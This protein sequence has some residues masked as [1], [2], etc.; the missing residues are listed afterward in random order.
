ML[1]GY[2]MAREKEVANIPFGDVG[3][4]YFIFWVELMVECVFAYYLSIILE[5]LVK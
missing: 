3:L 2:F 5:G 1:M 4:H